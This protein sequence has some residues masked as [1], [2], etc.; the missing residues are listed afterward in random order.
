MRYT[1]RFL[2]MLSANLVAIFA[3]GVGY[4]A[5]Y[6]GGSADSSVNSNVNVSI[7]DYA[8]L[9]NL[10]I[11]GADGLSYSMFFDV[12]SV[13]LLR[14]DNIT[15]EALF[16]I[17]CDF[18]DDAV[19]IPSGY[20]V[21]LVCDVSVSDSKRGVKNNGPI[22]WSESILDYFA[23]NTV[24]FPDTRAYDGSDFKLLEDKSSDTVEV[25]RAVIAEDIYSNGL[26]QY[27]TERFKLQFSYKD[28]SISNGTDKYYGSMTPNTQFSTTDEFKTAMSKIYEA[29]EGSKTSVT[30]KLILQ[31]GE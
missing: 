25:Y 9:G 6:F 22:F 13:S 3:V 27:E 16:K 23:P 11:I 1:R 17:K 14:S 31:K 18:S 30:F 26:S 12:D 21:A 10:V 24:L 2:M 28:Y 5:F 29:E 15:T 20:K 8:D 7:E 4:A 19:N